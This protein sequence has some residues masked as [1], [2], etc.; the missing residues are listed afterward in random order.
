MAKKIQ[1]KIKEGYPLPVVVCLS[2]K[3]LTWGQSPNDLYIGR[4]WS[5]GGW[6]LDKSKW[7]NPFKLSAYDGDISTVLK[8]YENYIEENESLI[9][10]LSELK[11]KN[12]GCFCK[13]KGSEHCHG[14]IL[15]KLYK[16]YILK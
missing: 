9:Q 1:I 6:K 16:K 8:L 13:K 12:L 15:L 11:G 10:S 14:D 4:Q 7:H 2:G 5:M 3:K